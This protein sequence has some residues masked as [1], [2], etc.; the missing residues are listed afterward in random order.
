MQTF[1]TF[2]QKPVLFLLN[3]ILLAFFVILPTINVNIRS[4]FAYMWIDS[5]ETNLI[6]FSFLKN[7]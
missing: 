7:T 2:L 3:N 5:F 4:W 6:I 1:R